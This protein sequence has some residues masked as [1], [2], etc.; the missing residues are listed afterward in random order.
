MES[1][2]F[3]GI[4]PNDFSSELKQYIDKKFQELE[5]K[6]NS[7]PNI[8]SRKQTCE[9]LDVTPSTLFHWNKK[10]I[11]KPKNISGRVYYLYDDI[12]NALEKFSNK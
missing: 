10:G 12:E 11:L 6:L 9:L 7:K 1:I 4:N 8:L 5:L 3:H 2:I